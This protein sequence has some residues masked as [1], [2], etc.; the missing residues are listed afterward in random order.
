MPQAVCHYKCIYCE[1][2]F[3][4][5]NTCLEHECKEHL[6]IS[7]EIYHEWEELKNAVARASHLVSTTKNA[8]TDHQFDETINALMAFEEKHHIKEPR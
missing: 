7:I 5:Y 4:T 6:H 3:P 1:Q 2:R 8:M